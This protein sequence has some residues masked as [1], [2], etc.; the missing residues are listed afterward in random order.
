MS[1]PP[2][3]GPQERAR[4]LL[5][6][7]KEQGY[8]LRLT[9]EQ[10]LDLSRLADTEIGR[11]VE[12][13]CQAGGIPLALYRSLEGYLGNRQRA[14][15][16]C[17]CVG[18]GKAPP[19]EHSQEKEKEAPEEHS[20]GGEKDLRESRSR[21]C[22]AAGKHPKTKGH[23]LFYK[24]GASL[25]ER[26]NWLLKQLELLAPENQMRAACNVGLLAGSFISIDFDSPSSQGELESE[27]GFALPPTF[28]VETG[29]YFEGQTLLEGLRKPRSE[30]ESI[31]ERQVREGAGLALL[32]SWRE[33]RAPS[34]RKKQVFYALPEGLPP[35][36]A[37]TIYYRNGDPIRKLDVRGQGA[38]VAVP[39]SR[40]YTR[41]FYSVLDAL[42]MR[43]APEE[44]VAL[45]MRGKG[46]TRPPS[47]PVI[48]IP[49]EPLAR[50]G[51]DYISPQRT[52]EKLD[53]LTRKIRS[54]EEGERHNSLK[55]LYPQGFSLACDTPSI[56]SEIESE[57][58]QAGLA[59]G[60]PAKEVSN[61][62][63]S[64][65][66]HA[67]ENYRPPERV[68]R[69]EGRFLQ[70]KPVKAKIESES[71]TLQEDSLREEQG[72]E[73]GEGVEGLPP[74]PSGPVFTRSE[75][76]SKIV[77]EYDR[78]FE[79][80]FAQAKIEGLLEEFKR[81]VHL[82]HSSLLE[83]YSLTD[84]STASLFLL[85]FFRD[86][87]FLEDRG[88]RGVWLV[89]DKESSL[90]REGSEALLEPLIRELVEELRER[91]SEGEF[92]YLQAIEE[93]KKSKT[94]FLRRLLAR[95]ETTKTRAAWLE[96][97]KLRVS[98]RVSQCN[99]LEP[100]EFACK[101][102]LLDLRDC[103]LSPLPRL[104]YLLTASELTP[105]K[106][107]SHIFESFLRD[108]FP[109]S[110]EMYQYARK[111]LGYCLTGS[112]R[113]QA[114]FLFVGV[115]AN[116]KSTLFKVLKRVLG[117]FYCLAPRGLFV[118]R[119]GESQEKEGLLFTTL[120]GK[121][122]AVC[123][124]NDDIDV[125]ESARIKKLTGDSRALA[126]AHFRDFEEIPLQ[127]KFILSTNALPTV[128]DSSEGMHRRIRVLRL[129]AR[130]ID[131]SEL[132][133]RPRRAF[134]KVREKD[135]EER[136]VTEEA[137]SGALH[138]L[139]QAAR[140][141]LREGLEDIPIEVSEASSQ[142]REAQDI[143]REFALEELSYD[144]NASTSAESL[145]AAFR[146]FA[147]RR[148][149][150]TKNITLRSWAPR[151]L[152]KLDTLEDFRAVSYAK[153]WR[154]QKKHFLGVALSKNKEEQAPL[155]IVS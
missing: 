97:V 39:P 27:L 95:F 90:W 122:L 79:L 30:S 143:L 96:Q 53:R 9:R 117:A 54:L 139:A 150:N 71:A 70:E 123:D 142:Y 131:K 125:L 51:S 154:S 18:E 84:S 66:K 76:G 7:S 110:P 47:P 155:K 10:A 94:G 5:R 55:K 140:D 106:S 153:D 4:A 129:Q 103:S 28:S 77:N 118:S 3:T 115:G 92:D 133:S 93:Q 67:E 114:F 22:S 86:V 31:P 20:Q 33:G 68:A 111:V 104:R 73:Q 98:I 69:P 152:S 57:L 147:E 74:I 61:L 34:I 135:Y 64:S 91:A 52:R 85:R 13:Y 144:P 121:R 78:A 148:G 100:Y 151:L 63:D 24:E 19:E 59:T 48:Q 38:L 101:G 50:T 120:A 108:V 49:R 87:R 126:R 83:L 15:L 132:D 46:E 149:E 82:A 112:V 37:S 113:E 99:Q 124:E 45:I 75:D 40:H 127:A 119:A 134:E 58:L 26:E 1:L 16:G 137:L 42:E 136:L 35:I 17:S 25:Q 14:F 105:S 56:S 29:F 107:K 65:K 60:L 11:A 72:E 130:F 41:A 62:F 44:L 146:K 8:R 138:F 2:R 128:P 88:S 12:I 102:G 80:A 21:F 23:G 36:K 141:Y 32:D 89:F 109:S 6:A 145:F 116:G 43:E 81:A